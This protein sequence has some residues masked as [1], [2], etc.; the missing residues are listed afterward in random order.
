MKAILI[1]FALVALSAAMQLRNH[2]YWY[3]AQKAIV[4]K[5]VPLGDVAWNYCDMKCTYLEKIFSGKDFV[6]IPFSGGTFSLDFAACYI[7]QTNNGT[8][9]YKLWNTAGTNA[10]YETN[11]GG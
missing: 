10:Y 5:K 1:V 9:T 8:T 7:Q 3:T 2:D 4:V 6:V 11:C